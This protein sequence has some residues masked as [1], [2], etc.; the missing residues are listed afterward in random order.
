MKSFLI[1]M[2]DFHTH[3]FVMMKVITERYHIV[4][5]YP[6]FIQCSNDKYSISFNHSDILNR[7]K[8]DIVVACKIFFSGDERFINEKQYITKWEYEHIGRYQ[9]CKK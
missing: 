6:S 4:A 8:D 2:I 9:K 3:F 5:E 7:I 1:K